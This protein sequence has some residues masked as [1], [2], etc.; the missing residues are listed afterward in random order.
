[1]S[2]KRVTINV[3]HHRFAKG[4]F[5]EETGLYEWD[6]NSIL[7]RKIKDKL[8]M[9][10]VKIMSAHYKILPMLINATKPDLIVSMHCNAFN[11]RASGREFLYY[12]GSSKSKEI[13]GIFNSYFGFLG[14]KDR[15]L[16]ALK[17]GDRGYAVV[18]KTR[19]PCIIAEPCFIDNKK[20]FLRFLDLQD[21]VV[22]A[23]V[24]AIIHSLNIIEFKGWK[25]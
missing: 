20:D 9:F 19:A 23:Y 2:K 17:K 14:N 4:A 15:G 25:K 21:H 8:T 13:A 1:M 5:S 3:G 18:K 11:K 24:D 16:K 22:N 7:A 12:S 6:I 10:E